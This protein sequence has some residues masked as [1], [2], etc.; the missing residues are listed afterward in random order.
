[1]DHELIAARHTARSVLVVEDDA[2]IAFDLRC[3][4]TAMGYYVVGPVTCLTD[5]LSKITD[6]KPD[7]AV[8]EMTLGEEAT[9]KVAESLNAAKIPHVFID[10]H[11]GGPILKTYRDQ[12]LLN[13]PYDYHSLLGALEDILKRCCR[14]EWDLGEPGRA[15]NSWVNINGTGGNTT[16]PDLDRKFALFL[17][18]DG[19]LVEIAATP[20]Q[21]VVAPRLASLLA[22]LHRELDGALAI[23]SGRPIAEIDRLLD[24]FRSSAAGEHGAAVRY[25]DGTL[26]ELPVGLAIPPLWRKSLAAA[27]D[28]LPGVRVETKPHGVTV[29]YRLAPESVNDVWRLM[30]ALVPS[31]HPRFKLVPAREAVEIGLRTVSKGDAV[32]RLMRQTAFRGRRPIF[33]G[34]DFTDEVGIRTA[35]DLGGMGLRVGEVFDGDPAM[36]RNWLLQGVEHMSGRSPRPTPTGIHL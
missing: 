5:A 28:H 11:A 13:N 16:P 21:V 27:A 25:D 26:E 9:P 3:V 34:D 22:E 14:L 18:L 30:R 32:K 17:D 33:V 10:G 35:R 23:V 4:L 7:A 12:P 29:H 20:D 36:V 15:Q 24:P 8:I 2:H 6:E 31:D 19:T 1:M